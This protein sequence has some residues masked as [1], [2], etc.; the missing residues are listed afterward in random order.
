MVFHIL[1][2]FAITRKE[3][4]Y[5]VRIYNDVACFVDVAHTPRF[6]VFSKHIAVLR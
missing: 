4:N 2:D 5:F 6:E 3:L 1:F